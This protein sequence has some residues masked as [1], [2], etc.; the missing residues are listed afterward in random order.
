M[1][2]IVFPGKLADAMQSNLILPGSRVLLRQGT[3]K[4]DFVSQL[5]GTKEAPITIQPYQNE[6]VVIDGGL[7]V[8]GSYTEWQG[9]E[10]TNSGWVGRDD[11]P[12][13]TG[14]SVELFGVGNKMTN[15]IIHDTSNNASWST[16]T[17]GGF[18]ECLIYNC[19]WLALDRGHG[20][21]IYIQNKY[22]T[23][24]HH[25][26]IIFGQYGYG[27]H[28]YTE[29]GEIDYFDL[30]ENICFRNGGRQ[31]LL[32][33]SGG[34]RAHNCVVDGNVMLEGDGLLKGTDIT[35][36]NNYSPNGFGI[37]A[38]SVNVTQSGNTFT[39]PKDGVNTFV[40]K[41]G[42]G[43]HIA[44]FN[45]SGLD[46]VELDLS[47][48]AVEKYALHNVQDYFVDILTGT[49]PKVTVDMRV[50]SHT[51]A[52]RI[53]SKAVETTFPSFGCFVLDRIN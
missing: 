29:T 23:Q 49:G 1:K 6:H 43:A 2:Q 36:T 27:I 11:A 50:A 38:T 10:F 53:G 19:G 42:K 30:R 35:L 8:Q 32:G 24:Y 33:G 21:G 41:T 44:I 5:S 46:S 25:R 12:V 39:T 7:K 13:V 26:N 47:A 3:Y 45:W 17:G 20:H 14:Q 40:F 48:L 15:C 34:Q 31:F 51:V 18:F 16:N 4:G 52:S 37:D 28:G 9:L 22:A